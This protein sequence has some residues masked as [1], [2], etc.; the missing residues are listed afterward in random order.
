MNMV[1]EH[2]SVGYHHVRPLRE[3]SSLKSSCNEYGE[4]LGL[5]VSYV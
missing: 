5:V 2:S 1:I 3:L 4:A